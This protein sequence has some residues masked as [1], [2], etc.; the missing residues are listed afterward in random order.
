MTAKL[1]TSKLIRTDKLLEPRDDCRAFEKL[2][3]AKVRRAEPSIF[4]HPQEYSPL[5][6]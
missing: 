4:F 3:E 5:S 1:D 6:E 2:R